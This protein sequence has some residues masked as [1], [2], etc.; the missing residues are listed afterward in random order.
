[1]LTKAKIREILSNR[2]EELSSSNLPHFLLLSDIK[3]ASKRVVNAIKNKEKIVVVGDYDVDG[4]SSS[5]IMKLFFEKIKFDIE[6]V[7]PD[8]FKDGYG[9]TPGLLE[10]IEADLIITVDNGITSFEAAEI[11]KQKRVDLI[12][13]DHHTPLI[14]DKVKCNMENEERFKLPDA[15]AI[16]NP[17][18]SPDFP[19]KEICGAE[20]AWYLCAAIK[21]EMK[22]KIDLREFTDILAIAII[23][24]VMPLT[25]MNRTLVNMGLKRLNKAVKPFSKALKRFFNKDFKAEDIAFQIA[26]RLNAAGRMF[27][28]G[29]AYEFLI[30][31]NEQ[32][33]FDLLME[34]DGLNNLRKETEKEAVE[35]IEEI[36]DDFIIVK[37]DFHEGVVGI[38]A[39]RLVHK[40]KK[41]AIVF[42]ENNGIL[43]GSG[44]SLG[45]IDIFSL[46]N[47]CK[48]LLEGFGGHKMACG[49]SLKEEN[50]EEL[51][52]VLNNKISKYSKDDFFIEDYVL[53]ELPFKEIDI[54]LLDILQEFEP[55]GEGNPK[56]KFIA[57]AKIEHVQNLKENHFKLI[58]SQ[59]DIVLPAV[60]FRFEGEFKDSLYFKFSINENSYYGRSVQLMIEE[61]L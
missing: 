20:V 35:S 39:S 45:N 13:T 23:A 40:Y 60:I 59:D 44:R 42:C 61:I 10:R 18:T 9:L 3:K 7:I 33:A 56:P 8:R 4:V 1:M 31:K 11:C 57:N 6:V 53:G 15:Y 54:E 47:E 28:A 12:I 30:S 50:F 37:G 25:H 38:I 24:D 22:L 19:F 43:K 32:K 27:H 48:E 51:K 49:L 52:K 58:L 16:I 5:A 46:V 26:P 34:L 17:K 29:V 14:M 2:I 21:S 55:F 41:P 36:T